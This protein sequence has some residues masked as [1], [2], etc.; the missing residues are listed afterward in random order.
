[1]H[2]IAFAAG[3][4]YVAQPVLSVLRVFPE[5][6]VYKWLH[7]SPE[8]SDKLKRQAEMQFAPKLLD[9]LKMTDEPS[10]YGDFL[11]ADK[12]PL[13]SP[14][15]RQLEYIWIKRVLY[16]KARLQKSHT[17][18]QKF[19]TGKDLLDYYRFLLGNGSLTMHDVLR[20]VHS[21]VHT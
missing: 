8:E 14:D 4:E 3:L 9:E 18:I 16:N 21:Q 17:V 11:D 6:P 7:L 1:M 5:T 13:K 15:I 19:R 10:F 12:V 20:L 2:T